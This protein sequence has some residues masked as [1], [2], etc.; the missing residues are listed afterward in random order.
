MISIKQKGDF[1]KTVAFLNKL[2]SDFIEKRLEHYG[3][4]GV[5]ALKAATPKDTGATANAWY[6]TS[7]KTKYGYRISWLNDNMPQ[8]IPVAVLIQYGH[9]TK[10]GGFVQGIDYINPAMKPVFEK[11][12]KELWDE[13][14]KA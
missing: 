1:K 7:A 9:A 5:E 14:E 4:L 6:F 13:V 2:D 8:G 10:N 11:I 3:K 12:A